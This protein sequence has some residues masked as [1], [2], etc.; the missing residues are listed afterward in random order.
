[1]GPADI[2]NMSSTSLSNQT[3][4]VPKLLADGSNWSMYSESIMNDL[5]LKGFKRHVLGT[6]YKLVEL[7][8]R[9][10]NK[11]DGQTGD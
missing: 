6:A 9:V 7:I 11:K 4:T 3:L 8:K 1:M 2:S 5:T 10:L